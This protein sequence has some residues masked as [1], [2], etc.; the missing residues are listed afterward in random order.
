MSQDAKSRINAL[1]VSVIG[2]E[3]TRGEATL[4]EDVRG[5]NSLAHI[6]LV[7]AMEREFDCELPE[8]VLLVGRPLGDLVAAV[9]ES[10]PKA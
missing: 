3:P 2:M 5:W 7:H 10:T 8:E 1:F 9:L 4:P 6:R